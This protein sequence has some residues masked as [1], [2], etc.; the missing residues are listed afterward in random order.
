MSTFSS[1]RSI[2]SSSSILQF[3]NEERKNSLNFTICKWISGLEFDV[4]LTLV[5]G[6]GD[7]EQVHFV[8]QRCQPIR[9][10]KVLHDL[11]VPLFFASLQRIVRPVAHDSTEHIL[12]PNHFLAPCVFSNKNNKQK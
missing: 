1:S 5:L 2:L 3:V 10:I 7:A 4:K 9:P 11:V 6:Y 8:C 12:F